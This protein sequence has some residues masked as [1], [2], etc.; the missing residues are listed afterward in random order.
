M[1]AL[2]DAADETPSRHADVSAYLL[3]EPR[4]LRD[5]CRSMQRDD[6]GRRCPQCCVR[7]FCDS[8]ARRAGRL[9]EPG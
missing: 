7:S 6:D 4:I 8:Q 5:V 2:S 9:G 3:A 1:F